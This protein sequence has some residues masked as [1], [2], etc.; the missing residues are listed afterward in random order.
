ME[1]E[2]KVKPE[3]GPFS[4]WICLFMIFACLVLV[5]CGIRPHG[6]IYT[7]IRLPLT[8]DLD[9]TPVPQFDPGSA[10]ILEIKEPF[11][12]LGIYARVH[13][14]AIGDIARENGMQTLYFAD[15]EIFSILGVWKTHRTLLYGK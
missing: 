1:T 7:N 14:N 6:L 8:E 9:H 11:T 2:T 12:G 4:R 10:R 5:A 13:S 3:S 15:Q